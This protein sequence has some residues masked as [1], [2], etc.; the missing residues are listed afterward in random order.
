MAGVIWL[1]NIGTEVVGIGRTWPSLGNGAPGGSVG[2][3][4]RAFDSNFSS[5]ANTFAGVVSKSP[6]VSSR[7]TERS[8]GRMGLSGA[9][10]EVRRMKLRAMLGFSR[11]C[12]EAP[13][14]I[15]GGEGCVRGG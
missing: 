2:S 15:S 8:V 7:R 10:S 12:E 6:D 14:R 9:P 1:I 5:C 13:C 11:T 3:G 4:D